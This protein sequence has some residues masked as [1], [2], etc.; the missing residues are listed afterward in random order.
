MNVILFDDPEVRNDL[1]PLTYT[2]PVAGIRMGILTIAEKWE[3][4]LRAKVSFSCEPYLSKKFAVKLTPDNYWIHG[5]LCPTPAFITLLGTLKDGDAIRQG[6]RMLAVRSSEDKRPEKAKGTV[7][8]FNDDITVVDKLWKIFQFNG[9]ELR[10]DF[11][12][13][14]TGRKS[15]AITDKGTVA[16]N[17]AGIFIEEGVMI[18]SAI[19]N[20]EPGPIYLGVNSQVQEGAIIRGPFCLGE[21]SIINLGGKMRGDTTIGPDCKVGGEISNSILFAHSNK[22]HDGFLGNSVLGEWCNLGAD[23]NTSNM[24]NTYDTVRLWNISKAAF[25]STG[26]TFCGLIMGDH[27]KAGINTMFNT[28]TIAGVNANIFGAGYPPNYIPSFSWGG[29][30]T[31]VLEKAITTADR[32]MK[33][34][35]SMLREEDKLILEK[36]FELTAGSRTWE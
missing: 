17:E 6:S 32:A 30:T 28:G 5:G 34:R 20:A 16:Y 19:L 3:K 11:T 14:T 9:K 12:L 1:L 29:E 10:A 23:T 7:H 4:H 18:K 36:V 31:Y 33:R 35:Q 2:R 15:A 22:S 25:E 21:G 8:D 13:L 24:K 26:L 27:S